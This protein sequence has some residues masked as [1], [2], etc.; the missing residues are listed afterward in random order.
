M[1][2]DSKKEPKITIVL[3]IEGRKGTNPAFPAIKQQRSTEP[4]AREN[5]LTADAAI[6]PTNASSP[7]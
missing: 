2:H 4:R 6:T 5:T 7:S 1:Y 3:H